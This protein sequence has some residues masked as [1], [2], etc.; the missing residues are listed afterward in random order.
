MMVNNP[1]PT[2][3]PSSGH[4]DAASACNAPVERLLD[5]TS[6]MRPNSTGSANCAQASSKL[7]AARSQPRRFSRPSASSTRV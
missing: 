1:N 6:M 7:A 5:S 4:G 2:Q 3:A